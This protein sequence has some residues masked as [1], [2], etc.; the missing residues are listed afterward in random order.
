M[1]S[2]LR[3]GAARRAEDAGPQRGGGVPDGEEVLRAPTK[4]GGIGLI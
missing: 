3:Q 1:A 2:G 4:A